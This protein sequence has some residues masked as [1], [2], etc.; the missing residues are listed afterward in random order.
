[1]CKKF[2]SSQKKLTYFS[3]ALELRKSINWNGIDKVFMS[4][5]VRYKT[6][7]VDNVRIMS[8]C[9]REECQ[10]LS[11]TYIDVCKCSRVLPAAVVTWYQIEMATFSKR[12]SQ[13][14]SR[15]MSM[16]LSHDTNFKVNHS[17]SLSPS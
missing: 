9:V 7:K 5:I 1:M 8:T 15:S 12:S 17:A 11:I 14:F 6:V 13:I 2:I 3:S 4:V 10:H 16:K